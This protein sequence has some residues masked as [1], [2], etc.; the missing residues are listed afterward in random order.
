MTTLRP[1]RT[2]SASTSLTSRADARVET[3]QRFVEN[4]EPRVVQQRAGQRD[5]L[6]HA[7]REFLAALVRV[8]LQ[9][10]PADEIPGAR[11]GGRCLDA[12]QPGNELEIFERR[13]LVVDH[14]LVGE[15]A[16]DLFGRNGIGDG[17]DAEDGD[18]ALVGLEQT[19]D[20]SKRRRLAGAVGAEQGIELAG[21]HGEVETVHGR[22]VK[23]LR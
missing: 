3:G 5:L 1:A 14:R 22:A 23:T 13:Q 12:P 17:I 18:R 4:D 7:A 10:E 15:P 21:P 11:F 2:L 20:H 9:T 16:D 6:A 19:A 8:G